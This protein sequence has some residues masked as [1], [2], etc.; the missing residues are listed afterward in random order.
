MTLE[1]RNAFIDAYMNN[2]SNCT[3]EELNQ[4]LD[5]YSNDHVSVD[6]LYNKHMFY[7]ASI[8]DALS[9]WAEASRFITQKYLKDIS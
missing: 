2:V 6:D 7:Y 8:M 5:D 4:F 1:E 9:I 3:K